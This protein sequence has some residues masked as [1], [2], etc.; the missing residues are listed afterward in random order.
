MSEINLKSPP[1]SPEAEQSILCSALLSKEARHIVFEKVKEQHFYQHKHQT[2]YKALEEMYIKNK[3]MDLITLQDQLKKSKDLKDIGGVS[4]IAE[5]FD[6]LPSGSN[7]EAYIE[8]LI[9]NAL[10]RDA[11]EMGKKIIDQSMDDQVEFKEIMEDNQSTLLELMEYKVR[12]RV[13]VLKDVMTNVINDIALTRD[14]DQKIIGISTGFKSLD[15]HTSGLKNS[16]LVVI[17]ARPSIGK[18]TFAVNIAHNI[19]KAGKGV[20]FFSLE[21]DSKQLGLKILSSESRIDSMKIQ[22]TNLKEDDYFKLIKAHETNKDLPLFFED[23][24]G[25]S[26]LEMRSITKQQMLKHKIDVI[27]IDYLQLMRPSK[28][29]QN[30]TQ[31]VSEVVREIKAFCKELQIPIIVLSQLSRSV[32]QRA[33]KTPM[34]SDLR[35][36]GEIEQTADIVMFLNREDYYDNSN[37]GSTDSSVDL[38]IAKNRTGSTG[39]VSLSYKRS[40]SKFLE[41]DFSR[42]AEQVQA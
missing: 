22:S 40:I 7:V 26:T 17:A 9:E 34:L 32:T 15:K 33:D 6:F 38:I 2:L 19:A 28:E 24:G 31:E 20:L 4:Y 21:M 10:K 1:N 14:K 18:T 23:T 16:E 37:D 12:K 25:L 5:L 13:V 42:S 30:R 41:F 39:K 27:V 3:E 11:M 8:I 29:T 35:E 36:T